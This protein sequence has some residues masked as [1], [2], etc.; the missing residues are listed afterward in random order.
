[1]HTAGMTLRERLSY[2]WGD[3]TLVLPAIALLIRP[4]LICIRRILDSIQ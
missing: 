3:P 2:V 1:M 4:L